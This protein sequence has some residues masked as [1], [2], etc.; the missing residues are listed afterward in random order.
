MSGMLNTLAGETQVKLLHLLRRTPRT[1]TELSFDLGLT[2]NAIRTHIAALTRDGLVELV[3]TQRDTG[4][5]PA[6]Q[7]GLTTVGGELFPKAYA[8][9]LGGLVEEIVRVEGRERAIALLKGV[10]TR[11]AQGVPPATDLQGRI[12]TAAATLRELGADVDVVTGSA[13][14]QLQGYAC[15]LSAVTSGHPEVC[16][17]VSALVAEITGRPVEEKCDRSTRPRC[18]FQI[19]AAE[20]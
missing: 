9:A 3:G 14:W 13:G 15:P 8:V 16:A 17:L 10:G 5:K 19:Q 1:I 12:S 4:G 11:V 6:R 18:R 7:Y 20:A 2:D